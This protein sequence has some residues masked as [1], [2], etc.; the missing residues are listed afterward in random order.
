MRRTRTLIATS[1]AALGLLAGLLSPATA[2]AE[3]F[4]APDNLGAP[5]NIAGV[6]PEPAAIGLNDPNCKLTPEH[7]RPVVLVHGLAA[8]ASE[9]WHVFAPFLAEKGFCVYGLTYGQVAAWP[10]RGGI[11]SMEDSAAQLGRFVDRVLVATGAKQ[12]DLV[13][14]SEGGIMPRWYLKFDGGA[15]KVAHFVAW[16]PPNHG[17]N[18]SGL[19]P[20][21]E[22]FPGFDEHLAEACGSCP[23]FL[24]GS[25]FLHKLNDGG[26]TVGDVRYTVIATRYDYLVTPIETSFLHG[27]NVHNILLQDEHPDA[28]PDH[29]ALAYDPTTFELTLA[30]L[31]YA[32]K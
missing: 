10:G 7:P 22:F 13:G 11:A 19:T 9:N 24:P 30:G 27:P 8:T 18:I 28:R 20:L 4:G 17:T 26:D 31:G 1:V 5:D 2:R 12:V 16:A 6:L 29:V 15:A 14:H 23:E 32:G 21:R 3:A 25:A